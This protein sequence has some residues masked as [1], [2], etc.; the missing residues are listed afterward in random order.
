MISLHNVVLG[1]NDHVENEQDHPLVRA[2]RGAGDVHCAV[3]CGEELPDEEEMELEDEE[4][5]ELDADRGG[6]EE[7]EDDTP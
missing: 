4:S 5:D 3:Y 6:G 2:D 1:G 7:S